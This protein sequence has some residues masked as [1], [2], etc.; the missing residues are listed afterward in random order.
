[1]KPDRIFLVRHGQSI[2]NVNKNVYKKIPD[3][4][5]QLSEQG[6]KEAIEAGNQIKNIIGEESL[7]CY[8]SPFW[9]TRQTYL[10]IM[11]AFPLVLKTN[12]TFYEDPRL[13]E[14]E[15]AGSLR[16]DGYM[17]DIESERDSFGHFYYRFK[18]G[19]SCADVFDRIS[20]FLDTLH[21]DFEKSD[22]PKNCIIVSHG[23]TLRVFLMRFFHLSVEEFERLKN[24]KNCQ[25]VLLELMGSKYKMIKGLDDYPSLRHNYQFDWSMNF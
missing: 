23:M 8:I 12:K 14:Q 22:F 21:R 20:G 24:P 5:L 25:F 6:K 19:E 17:A 10:G 3:Y 9:R 2:G 18:G 4:A 15:W 1:M 11:K 16:E 13:R 7:K